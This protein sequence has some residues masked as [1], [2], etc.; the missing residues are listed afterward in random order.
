MPT[1]G[2]LSFVAGAELPKKCLQ[3]H[4]RVPRRGCWMVEILGSFPSGNA[5]ASGQVSTWRGHEH[6]SLRRNG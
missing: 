3:P 4:N 5:P 6:V 2:K 1:T